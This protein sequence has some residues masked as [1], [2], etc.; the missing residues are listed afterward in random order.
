MQNPYRPA[1]ASTTTPVVAALLGLNGLFFLAQLVLGDWLLLTFALWPLGAPDSAGR[2]LGL[3]YVPDFRLWQLV[4]Y[5]FLHGN[6]LHLFTNMF[7]M[8]MFGVQIERLWGSRM[9]AIYYFVCVLGAGVVQ[10]LVASAA[11]AEI[12]PYPTIGASGGVFGILLAFGMM[13]PNQRILLLFPPIPMRA[14]WFV[15]LYG[16]FELYAGITGTLSGV[17]HFAHLGGMLFGFLLIQY[18]RYQALRGR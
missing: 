18:W 2:L 12:G 11:V 9:F 7:A 1:H 10:L 16:A 8:W 3:P 5:S 17:A 15:I 6:L 4:S 13:F 14:K